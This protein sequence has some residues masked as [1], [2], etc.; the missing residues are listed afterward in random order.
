MSVQSAAS[1]LALRDKFQK[2]IKN[3]ETVLGAE[4]VPICVSGTCLSTCLS[5]PTVCRNERSDH[6]VKMLFNYLSNLSVL[7]CSDSDSSSS[8]S[9]EVSHSVI[10]SATVSVTLLLCQLLTSVSVYIQSELDVSVDSCLQMNLVYQQVVQETLDQLE[11]LL[12]QNHRQQVSAKPE[13]Q[14]GGQC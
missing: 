10:Y 5:V 13:P 14:T 12:V 7:L 2:D 6:N 3:L 9:E 1:L 4:D 8:S 11:T